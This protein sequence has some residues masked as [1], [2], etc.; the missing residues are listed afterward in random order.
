MNYRVALLTSHRSGRGKAAENA[1]LA[2]QKLGE[3][4]AL[5][6]DN[7]EG[8]TGDIAEDVTAALERSANMVA[9]LGGDGYVAK[10]A[11]RMAGTDVTVLPLPGGRGNDFVRALGIAPTLREVLAKWHSYVPRKIDVMRLR[12]AG[13]RCRDILGVLSNGI[14]AAVN[15][16]ANKTV[17]PTALG[18]KIALLWAA[19]RFRP[20]LYEISGISEDG[21]HFSLTRRSFLAAVS[22]DGMFGGGINVCPSSKL[23]DGLLELVTH[24]PIDSKVELARVV[25]R[26][27]TGKIHLSPGYRVRRVREVTVTPLF[28][29]QAFAD[30]DPLWQGM[31]MA[32]ALPKHLKVLAPK[33]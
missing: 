26:A 27:L 25:K 1:Q 15:D 2:A 33:G 22:N 6:F 13:G 30:G 18:Y 3:G 21:A 28:P 24:D 10:V 8:G 11:T 19:A 14:D 9:I 16:A 29:I 12:G 5:V 31:V 20:D 23:D 32:R 7:R 17:V 4:A